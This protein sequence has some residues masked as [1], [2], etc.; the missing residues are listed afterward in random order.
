MRR[1]L[2]AP[3]RAALLLDLDGTLLDFAA[4]P[5]L[6][7][8]PAGLTDTL[9]RLRAPL[10]DALAIIT[11]RRIAEIDA[12][13]GDAPF[14]VAG[15]HGIAIRPGPDAAEHHVALPA[16]PPAWLAEAEALATAHPGVLLERKSR[17]FVLH[18]RR[19]P[20]A[21][22]VLRAALERMR[23]GDPRFALLAAAMAWEI[24]PHGADKGSALRALMAHPPFAA[25]LPVFIGDDVTDQDAI[26]AAQALGGVGLRV[27]DA[28][29]GPTEVRA[30]LSEAARAGQWPALPRG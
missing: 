18:Y 21:G 25:R 4:R 22:P 19:A 29:G 2:P 6:V 9:R 13:L 27:D 17:G 23:H 28:F 20:G 12:L 1:A 26:D 30:W 5:D 10:G 14:A 7:T 8:V 24:R 3:T 16:I 11:G 15:E